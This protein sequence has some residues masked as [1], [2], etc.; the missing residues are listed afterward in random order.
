MIRE[1]IPENIESVAERIPSPEEVLGLFRRLVGSEEFKEVRR[2]FDDRGLFLF[3][4]KIP[5]EKPGEHTE[6]IYRREGSRQDG[7][8]GPTAVHVVFFKNDEPVSGTAVA[9]QNGKT[10]EWQIFQ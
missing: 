1:K 6:Y 10:G 9:K 2:I 5:G 8:S 4:I 7:T 3:E